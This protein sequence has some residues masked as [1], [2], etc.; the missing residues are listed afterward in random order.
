MQT[1]FDDIRPYNLSEIPPAMQRIATSEH[2]ELL[3]NY[4]FPDRDVED[5]RNMVHQIRTTDEF[6][7]K[8]MYFVN[9]EIVRRSMTALSYDGLD[10]LNPQTNYLFVSNHRDIM[11]D[12]SL[13]QYILHFNNFRTTEITFGSNLMNPQLVVD[14]GKANKMFKVIRSSNIREFLKNSLHLSE[15]IRHTITEKGESIWIA[16]RN[17]RTKNGYD[18]TDQGIIKMFCMSKSSDLLKAIDELHIV[19]LSISYQIESCDI[20]KTSELYHSQNGE[21]YIKQPYEDFKSILTGI[22]QPKGYVHLSF[23]KPLTSEELEFG[24]K[25]PNE[26]YKSVATLI[27]E[28]IYGSYK[29]SDNN[30]IAHDLRSGNDRFSDYYTNE[31]K[32]AFVAR[33]RYML[34]QIEG[35]NDVLLSLFLGIYANPV[36]TKPKAKLLS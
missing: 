7:A 9:K 22:Q 24:H 36:D 23:C 21:K 1:K 34:E 25:A 28:R 14:I 19:P 33:S 10:Q 30:Y 20:L 18:A 17:G 26:F 3:S 29:L 4:I 2:F 16:Q 27:D 6:Q 12:S 32:E 35:D 31:A 15:Y 13:L 8:V 5:V 11:L